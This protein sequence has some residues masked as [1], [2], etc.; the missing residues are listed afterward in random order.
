M[1]GPYQSYCAPGLDTVRL[2]NL[3]L[4]R[5]GL[6]EDH[7]FYLFDFFGKPL[8]GPF[9]YLI[10]KILYMFLRSSKCVPSFVSTS[11]QL[12]SCIIAKLKLLYRLLG[13]RKLIRRRYE[14]CFH[15][16]PACLKHILVLKQGL[17][18]IWILTQSR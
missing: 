1:I 10:L 9:C 7:V 8:V 15:L 11:F 3:P 17:S 18:I 16:G 12:V 13:I 5:Q 2:T 4:I 6:K 14:S